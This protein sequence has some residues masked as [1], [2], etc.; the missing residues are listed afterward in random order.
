MSSKSP[1]LCRVSI[2]SAEQTFETMTL[3][4]T[5][6]EEKGR[7]LN[8]I[9]VG[10]IQPKRQKLMKTYALKSEP[11]ANDVEMKDK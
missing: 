10:A 4:L 6:V 1:V 5:F 9:Q 7:F 8:M 2:A 11:T 3:I